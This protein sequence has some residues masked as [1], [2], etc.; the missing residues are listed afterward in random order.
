MKL[1]M[2]KN[3][4]PENTLKKLSKQL[5]VDVLPQKPGVYLFKDIHDNILYVGKAINLRKRVISY[6]R[7]VHADNR[8]NKL[9]DNVSKF[10]FIEAKTEIETLLLEA[11]L[12]QQYRPK[13]N[14]LLKDNRRY[15]YVGISKEPFARLYFLRQPEIDK[16][17]YF[18]AGPF[19]TSQ[20]IREVMRLL[21]RIFPYR[22]CDKIPGK[23]CLYFHLKLCLG[24]CQN[25]ISQKS[26]QKNIQRIKLFLQGNVCR[27]VTNLKKEMDS[28][29]EKMLFEK[30]AQKKFQILAIERMLAQFKKLP[31]ESLLERQLAWIR[32]I[33]IK[34]QG[35]EPL[36]LKRIEGYDIS[37]LGSGIVVASMVVFSSG[38]E[39]K[40][41]YRQFRIREKGGG[42]TGAIQEVI[43]RR[44]ARKDWIYPQLLIV[45]GGKPQLSAA[46]EILGKTSGHRHLG[47]IGIT[48]EKET[49]VIPYFKDEKLLFKMI[50]NSSKAIGL[51]LIQNI[52]DESHR[53]AQRYYKK[54]H[55]RVM[56]SSERE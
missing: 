49:L 39:D 53:F 11:N 5:A 10:D 29:S 27:L 2:K 48:K 25:N 1:S 55:R 9:L 13:Y 38:E 18:W 31:D 33:L 51:P 4:S 23:T 44:F 43:K 50:K 32:E 20:S 15:L 40:N 42:D 52:R 12:I 47:I 7:G 45:D 6:F 24:P 22:S 21:R 34:Y 35:V 19:P 16:N 36:V 56:F 30:A 46:L 8:I 28:Y 54:L 17:L 26:Y 41:Q 14:V 3:Q 37:N